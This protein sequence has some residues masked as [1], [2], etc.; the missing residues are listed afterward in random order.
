MLAAAAGAVSAAAT[1]AIGSAGATAASPAARSPRL[2]PVGDRNPPTGSTGS[3]DGATAAARRAAHPLAVRPARVVRDL[4]PDA[5]ANAVA[6]TFDDGPHP[7]WT[8]RVLEVLRVH[9]VLATF[10][11]IG[12]QARAHPALVRRI[13]AEGHTLCNHTMSHPQPFSQR[14]EVEIRAEITRAQEAIAAVGGRSPRLFRAPGGDWSAQVLSVAADLGLAPLGWRVDPRDWA[15]PG[16]DAIVRALE[17]ARAGDI[18]LCHDGG[19]DRSQTVTALARVL[20][21]LRARGLCFV[22]L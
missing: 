5:P 3:G 10:C 8:P 17:A 1:T 16:T 13:L 7:T 6:L 22:A 2:V 15:R 9:E 18:L 4:L 20:P 21:A 14:P 19:G 11:L 12:V